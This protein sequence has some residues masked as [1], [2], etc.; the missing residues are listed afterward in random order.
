MSFMPPDKK[1]LW[2]I[3]KEKVKALKQETYALYLAYRDPRTPWYARVF[4]ILV[5]GYAFS[6]IDLVPDFIPVFGYLDDLVLIPLG[7]LL[8]RKM[9]PDEVMASCREKATE[10]LLNNRPNSTI[11]AAVIV[12]IWLT[13]AILV[14]LWI[15]NNWFSG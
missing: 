6:P 3:W 13:G 4:A 11:A 10:S 8:A 12:L 1:S 2:T 14:G 5:V 9:I 15:W 7:I